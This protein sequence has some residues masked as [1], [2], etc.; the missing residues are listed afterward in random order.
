MT[1]VR[2]PEAKRAYQR[3]WYRQNRERTAER[4]TARHKANRDRNF[5]IID[6]LRDNTPCMDCGIQY[7]HYVMDFDHVRGEKI[8]DVTL[9]AAYGWSVEKLMAEIAK[10]EIVCSNCHRARTWIRRG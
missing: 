5:K 8:N 9:G 7:P 2:D 1:S 6:D 10:C 4:T 3:E